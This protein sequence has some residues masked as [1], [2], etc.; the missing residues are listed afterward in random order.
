MQASPLRANADSTGSDQSQASSLSL[1]HSDDVHDASLRVA[2]GSPAEEGKTNMTQQ[3]KV[4][5]HDDSDVFSPRPIY[6]F[7][8]A[9]RSY[10]QGA[11]CGGSV[12]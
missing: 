10:K 5:N 9:D 4:V 12:T 7:P 3:V 2:N 1:E 8:S 11:G 6:S